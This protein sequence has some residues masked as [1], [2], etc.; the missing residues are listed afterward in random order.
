MLMILTGLIKVA[1]FFEIK[2]VFWLIPCSCGCD[3]AL[4]IDDTD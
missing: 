2:I 1:D 4:C 3:F